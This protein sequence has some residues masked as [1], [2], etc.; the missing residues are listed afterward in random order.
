MGCIYGT[1]GAVGQLILCGSWNCH[2]GGG[3]PEELAVGAITYR[4]AFAD[5][6]SQ[7]YTIV[8]GFINLIKLHKRLVALSFNRVL[9]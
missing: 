6:L 3:K 4:Q 1:A 8:L 2:T 9:F 5:T 7:R